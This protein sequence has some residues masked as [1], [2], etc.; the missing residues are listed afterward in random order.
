M[1]VMVEIR[2]MSHLEHNSAEIF[3][4][5]ALSEFTAHSAR[6]RKRHTGAGTVALFVIH[7]GRYNRNCVATHRRFRRRRPCVIL[8]TRQCRNE[9]LL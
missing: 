8:K 1:Y 6:L 9:A 5:H 7:S 3:R 2:Y 4:Y